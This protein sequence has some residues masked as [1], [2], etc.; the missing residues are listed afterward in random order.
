VTDVTGEVFDGFDTEEA[1][2]ELYELKREMED[3][4]ARRKE[5]Q[6]E[7]AK[8]HTIKDQLFFLDR[9]GNKHTAQVVRSSIP[10]I[11]VIGLKEELPAD[12]FEQISE[13]TVK[14][15]V[16]EEALNTGLV[17]ESIARRHVQYKERAPYVK[18]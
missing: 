16:L 8:R 9:D 7:I 6:A 2:T 3:L 13:H 11:D 18:F 12:V 5:L 17:P 1:L 4:D 14:A 10:V 15:K